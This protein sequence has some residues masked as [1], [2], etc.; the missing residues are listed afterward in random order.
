M[1]HA[2]RCLFILLAAIMLCGCL[3]VTAQAA[4][5][6]DNNGWY[7]LDANGNRLKNTWQKDAYGWCYIGSD[8]YMVTNDWAKDSQG[9]CYIGADGYAV[10]NCWKQDSYGWIWLNS[11]GSMT[12]NQWVKDGGK[13]YYLDANGYMATNQW[14][15]DSQGWCY[16]GSNG[17][18]VTNGWAQ[19]SQGWCYLGSNGYAVTNCWKKDSYGWIWLDSNGS[20]TKDKWIKDGGKWYYLDA[21]GYM[22]TNRWC[23]DSIGWCYVGSNGAMVTNDWAKD[24]QG[25]CYLGSNGYA[26]TNTWKQD[27]QGWLYLGPNGTNLKNSWVRSGNNWY[28]VGANGYMVTGW[29]TIGGNR[30][31]FYTSGVM[32]ANTTIDGIQIGSDGKANQKL[33][34]T[35]GL[36]TNAKIISLEVNALTKWLEEETGYELEFIEYAGG[37]DVSTQISTTIAAG[38]EL[39]DILYGLSLNTSMISTYGKDGYFV[40]L[41]PYYEDKN[42][43]SKVF[44]DR[45]DACLNEEDQQYVLNKIVDTDTN[46]IYGVPIIETSLVDKRK[47]Q[48]W[49]N[50]VWLDK[51]GLDMPTNTAEL[52]EVLVAFDTQD[53]NGNGDPNDEIPLFGSEKAGGSAGVVDW[54]VN[55]F[56]YYNP[57][58]P[59]QDYDGDGELE[60][61]YT[62]DGYR[63]AL[64][65]VNK[66]YK[67]GLLS[68]MLY[69]ASSAEMKQF[70]TPSSGTA[71]C[72]VFCGHLT[73][74]C[75]WGNEVMYEYVPM[76]LW[77][78]AVEGD[79]T[80]K[81]NT[82]ITA[83]CD[84][85]D[86]AFQLLMKL[87]SWE[88]SMRVR[89]G[90]YG[91]NWTDADPGTK[92]AM[93]LD[94]TFKLL[95]DPLTQKST[96]HWGTIASCFNHYAEGETA[97]I[98]DNIDEWT[99]KKSQM[100]AESR[101]IFDAA[102]AANNPTN[103]TPYLSYT[104]EEADIVAMSKSNIDTAVS[105]QETNFV[106][107]IGGDINS[108]ADWNSYLQN[109]KK[110]GLDTYQEIAQTVYERTK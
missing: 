23:K 95:S 37:T 20:M 12:K 35:I 59:W 72:G 68:N 8:G 66:L 49:I 36:P 101:R 87:F 103:L 92:S 25:W 15:K 10:T 99:K 62:Q 106:A 53:A 83:D 41:T 50:Q 55:M 63:E 4:W 56:I 64:R 97:Q 60:Y 52:Y 51:L 58:H 105:R 39:P 1:K 42:G 85:P 110:L 48:P 75:T 34:L 46:E 40:N 6:K 71:L 96:A 84:Y 89:Y 13:W 18:M 79:Q 82:F 16:L 21:N 76:P 57:E 33:T 86:E 104:R 93:G 70:I 107:G 80:C 77:G 88:G 28:Y 91:V 43:A 29:Q 30:Y 26:L 19:D 78:Y 109:L 73:I 7:Y 3:M 44:W 38:Q 31:Y 54:L 9:W 61:V 69:T 24:S 81:L 2:K 47:Y 14:R 100:H 108:D 90:E 65:F 27:G 17:A 22:A 32:A 94:A 5:V 45:L 74:H 98:A 67:E 102:A 11:N